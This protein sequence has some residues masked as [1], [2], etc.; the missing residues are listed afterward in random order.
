MIV[1][2]IIG[3]AEPRD[4]G[5]LISREF[6][7]LWRNRGNPNALTNDAYLIASKRSSHYSDLNQL[8]DHTNGIVHGPPR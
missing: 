1:L 6:A 3:T 7:T 5:G 8:G 2:T 4:D